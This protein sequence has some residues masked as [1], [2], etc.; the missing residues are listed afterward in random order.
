MKDKLLKKSEILDSQTSEAGVDY[1]RLYHE[2]FK[3]LRLAFDRFD[4]LFPRGGE[5]YW[6]NYTIYGESKTKCKL[7]RGFKKT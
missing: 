3:V 1:E 4:F 5:G 2:R 7:G 6:L